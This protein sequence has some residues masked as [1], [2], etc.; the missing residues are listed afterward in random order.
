MLG[1]AL[2]MEEKLLNSGLRTSVSVASLLRLCPWTLLLPKF[3]SIGGEYN[4]SPG[5]KW[6][7]NRKDESPPHAGPL[8]LELELERPKEPL[9]RGEDGGDKF[10]NEL[11][12]AT[13]SSSPVSSSKSMLLM[14]NK[15]S[16]LKSSVVKEALPLLGLLMLL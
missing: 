5:S 11:N 14:S 1:D 4:C 13:C 8:K 16:I 12:D 9:L 2:S 6:S 10:S 3:S 15:S 7:S